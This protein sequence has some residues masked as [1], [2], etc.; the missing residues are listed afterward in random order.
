MSAETTTDLTVRSLSELDLDDI[1][2]IVEATRE[3]YQPDLW[4][5]RV[6]Y[7]LRRDPEGSVVAEADGRV[8]GFMLGDVRAGDFGLDEPSGWI[9]VIGVDPAAAGRG[10]G[11]ALARAILERYR[12][13]GVRTVRTMVD[14]SMPEVEAFF[15]RQGFE[16]DSLRP[17]VKR[18]QD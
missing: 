13:R 2:R 7:Y 15:V 16:A 6:T 5:D 1:V 4:E 9:E 11:H 3:Q 12:Q 18:L 14:S 10:V 17:F 8:V